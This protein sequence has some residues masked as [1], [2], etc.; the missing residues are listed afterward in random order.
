ML[1]GIVDGG[2]V[3]LN[4][5]KLRIRNGHSAADNVGEGAVELGG[6]RGIG[7]ILLAKSVESKGHCQ[8]ICSIGKIGI[9]VLTP[10]IL[11]HPEIPIAIIKGWLD[12]GAFA[13]IV[14]CDEMN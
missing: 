10:E 2:T 12:Y 8:I 5:G 4:S 3:G 13:K 14:P 11:N 7:A 6:N 9:D 1:I